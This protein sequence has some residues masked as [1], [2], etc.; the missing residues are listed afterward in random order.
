MYKSG[1]GGNPP[2][3]DEASNHL[4]EWKV[5]RSVLASFDGSLHDLRKYGFSFVTALLAAES[6]LVPGPVAI[7]S[8]KEALPP[9]IKLCVFAVTLLLID[10]LQLIDKN[11]QVIQEAAADRAL[12]LERELNLELSEVISDRYKGV[13]FRVFALYFAL[14]L[15]VLYL[16]SLVLYP[17]YLY[18]GVLVVLEMISVG[19]LIWNFRIELKFREGGPEWDWTL[20][21]LVC[22]S[23]DE[24][25]IT[26]TNLTRDKVETVIPGLGL[27]KMPKPIV[28]KQGELVWDV[29]NQDG[30][31]IDQW[32]AKKEM[33]IYDGYTWLWPTKRFGKGIYR[34]RPRRWSLP[35]H[36]KIIVT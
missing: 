17:D 20:S 33:T 32:T 2:K 9:L 8:G 11:Y 26:L 36:R 25:K 31:V 14:T 28:F 35:L 29:E 21:P 10:A 18:V 4:E 3:D 30:D 12:V 24:V 23:G 5:A 34:V 13:H 6:I 7:A 15:G 27:R 1:K 16:G 19:F 22:Q